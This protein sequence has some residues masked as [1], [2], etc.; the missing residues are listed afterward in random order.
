MCYSHICKDVKYHS[1]SNHGKQVNKVIKTLFRGLYEEKMD[2]TQEIF[3][4]E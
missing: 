1:D 3:L 4:T 2:V